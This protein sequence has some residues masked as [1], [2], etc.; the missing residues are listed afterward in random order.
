LQV[1]F[2]SPS[3]SAELR[4]PEGW[5]CACWRDRAECACESVRL[6]GC[7]TSMRQV[8][9]RVF[10]EFVHRL[11]ALGPVSSEVNSTMHCCTR[12]NSKRASKLSAFW[13][14][15]LRAEMEAN[16]EYDW[17]WQRKWGDSAV[18]QVP[19]SEAEQPK[20]CCSWLHCA[21]TVL[22]EFICSEKGI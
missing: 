11:W 20:P 1:P 21:H 3:L 8:R 7:A 15:A 9:D 6:I 14:T 5:V 17:C 2:K 16:Q 12:Q 22:P 13:S 4:N 19:L 18:F 10:T